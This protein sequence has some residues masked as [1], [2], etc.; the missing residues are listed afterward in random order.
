[1]N[2]ADRRTVE[3][4]L[5]TDE[6]QLTMGQLYF[7]LGWHE[8]T[9]QFDHFFRHYP[10]YGTHQAG[11]CVNA[12]LGWLLDWM[13]AARFRDEDI[14]YL[15]AQQRHDGTPLF[16]EDYLAWLKARWSRPSCSKPPCST[17]STTRR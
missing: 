1:M 7:R 14:A 6:Y 16:G 15:R 17:T 13:A 3:G 12:G 11:Y 9:V 2:A 4:I 5:F 8:R 10:D